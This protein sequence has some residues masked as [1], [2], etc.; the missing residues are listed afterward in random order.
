VPV[1]KLP[2]LDAKKSAARAISS[3]R[4]MRFKVKA[5]HEVPSSWIRA[6]EVGHVRRRVG[7]SR[8]ERIDPDA[9]QARQLEL[10]PARSNRPVH[11]LQRQFEHAE[12]VAGDA[13]SAT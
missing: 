13:A 3:G 6:R 12:L 7:S 11:D 10:L 5:V 4:A 1:T 2:A 8:Q 9:L